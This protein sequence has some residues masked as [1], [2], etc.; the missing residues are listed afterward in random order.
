LVMAP[1]RELAIQVEKVIKLIAQGLSSV[2]IYGGVSYDH[3]E[4]ALYRGVDIVVGT[5]GR[6]IDHLERQNLSLK[7]LKYFVCDEADEMLN[8]GF[9][10]PIDRIM[11][12]IPRE[13]EPQT[14]LFSAT[15]PEWVKGL[16]NKYLKEDYILV[17]LVVEDKALMQTPVALTHLAIQTSRPGRMAALADVVKCYSGGGKTLV[18]CDTKAEAND[19]GLSSSLSKLCQVLHGDISQEQR[20]VTLAAFRKNV[21]S[22]LVATDVAARGL[23][24][25]GV[26][27]IIHC[28]PPKDIEQYIHRSG[29]TAR[30]GKSGTSVAFYMRSQ[31]YV[32]K[33]IETNAK[34]KFA[35]VGVPQP[36][37]LYK[38]S[39]ECAT[40][41]ISQVAECLTPFFVPFAKEL[42][43]KFDGNAE[44]ALASALAVI[45]GHKKAAESRSLLSNTEGYTTVMVQAPDVIKSRQHI[46]SVI[47]TELRLS[48]ERDAAV[49]DVRITKDGYAGVAD[50]PTKFVSKLIEK[51]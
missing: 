10:E 51:K 37:D 18:F 50:I 44:L 41:E 24:I 40:E 5:P 12:D 34:I 30:A 46:L 16:A 2:C 38:V 11:E 45:G 17:D 21:F 3:Q 31:E 43:I 29:R 19:V 28:T 25:E 48:S 6:V 32:L 39:A 33:L 35:R 42:I 26:D 47:T 20:E 27:L 1:T 4:S 36:S 22:V 8:M 15:I 7:N 13:N 9:R 23:D 49:G 14:L